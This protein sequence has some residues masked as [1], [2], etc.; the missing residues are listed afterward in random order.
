MILAIDNLFL[1][2][3]FNLI[4]HLALSPSYIFYAVS[5]GLGANSTKLA[6]NKDLHACTIHDTG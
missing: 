2:I 6:L 5:E 3:K 4:D 1:S